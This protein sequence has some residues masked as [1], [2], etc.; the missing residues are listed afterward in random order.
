MDFGKNRIQYQNF[1][2]TY[3]DFERYRV[4]S[5]QGG[6]EISKYVSV[7]VAKQ[8]PLLEKR[9]DYQVDDKINI[10]V[11]NNQG[12]FKQS[13]LGLSSDDQNNIGGVTK[14]I[15][16]KISVFFNGSHA[17][18]DQQ[19]RAAL[20]ELLI[21][22]ILYGGNARD[23]LRNSTLLNLPPWYTQG[24]I[25]Y[26]SEGWTSYSDNLMYDDIKNDRFS[27]FNRLTG[28]EA[29]RAGHALWYDIVGTYGEALIP[30]LLYMTRVS[31]SPDNAFLFVLGV[32]L[33]N[34]IYDFTDAYNRRLFTFKDSLRKSPINN[35]SV[36]KKYK[37]IRH[38]S[39]LKLSPD[40][41]KVVYAR[42]ELNQIRVYLNEIG[43]NKH[44]RL[45]KYGPKIEQLDD[46]TYPILAWHPNG[47]IV[48]MI[49][50]R[51]DQ[52]VIYTV[53]L[54]SK[55]TFRRNLPGF[56]KINSASY[57]PDGKKLAL[58]AV[59][60]GKGQSDI[61]VYG[62]SSSAIEQITND[63]W[64]D[65]NAVFIKGSKQIVFESNRVN[66]TVKASDDASFFV[67]INRN[68]DLFMAPYPFRSKVLVRIT[69]TPDVNE[70]QAQPYTEQYVTYLSD[71]NGIYNRYIAEY[72]SSI[73]FVDTTE[74]YR[75]FFK[76]KVTSNFDRNLLE[77]NINLQ[78][79][80][81]ADVIFANGKNMLLV[82]PITTKLNEV[83]IPE[84]NNT[85]HK[86][87]TRPIVT[88]PS[89]YK[90]PAKPAE[91]ISPGRNGEP[92]ESGI[93]FDNYKFDGE[94][95]PPEKPADEAAK[96]VVRSDSAAKKPGASTAF[97]FPIQRNYYT[98]FYTDYVVT[99]F[100]NSFLA[101]NYQVFTGGGAP[102]YLNPGFNFLSK[103][104][105]SDLFEDQ[106]IVGG[107]RLNPSLDNEFMLSW[108]QRKKLFDHQVVLDRQTY[109]RAPITL[110][111]GVEFTGKVVTSTFK[112]S[113]KYPFNPVAAVRLSALLRNDKT[114][115]L[116]LGDFSLPRKPMFENLAGLRM[117]YIFDNTRKVMLNIMNGFRFKVWTEYWRFQD[118]ER[119]DLFTSGFDARHYLKI[120]RQITWCNRIAG[121]NSLGTDRLIFYLGGVDNWLNPTFNTNINIVNPSQYGFQTLATN[122]RGFNQNIRNGNNF[123][124]YNSELRI[125]VVRYLLNHPVRSDFLNNFQVIG[126]MDVG[127]AWNGLNPL[128][129]ENTENT[130]DYYYEG[131]SVIVTVVNQKNPLVAGTGFGLRS[132]L[133]GYF[134]RLD[135][136]WGIDNWVVQKRIIGLSL[137]T[138]F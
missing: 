127:M 51:K 134:V 119:R 98:S 3:F 24:L 49:Y 33:Q 53:D 77:Q 115:A 79:T 83:N 68:M 105:I 80:H 39:Q 123:L 57:S 61:F 32:S 116:S 8:L 25:K 136:G 71:K 31:R 124:V 130:Q 96:S 60:K 138:D 63:I 109:A 110:P 38:Y 76:S 137:T 92:T 82:T 5:Y 28:D 35:N 58:S 106:R 37:S 78:G 62:L 97:R 69:N 120:H 54:E 41:K 126:F 19:I 125:P 43:E 101:N 36:L 117:E 50:E 84:P 29:A 22:K 40:G 132:R 17:D 89:N 131:T 47:N 122:M 2:W 67:K 42:T 21:T 12:D 64:D 118:K 6:A 55:E 73:A 20:A 72:D 9:L 74:H 59:K 102:I 44:K 94:K 10:L 103:V 34:L 86:G 30:N 107:F 128:S 66:D 100:D 99:Q 112:Y 93:D 65:N 14:I 70:T 88:D 90:D 27:S 48:A 85:W 91:N 7:S 26:L 113:V 46:F 15:G 45:L 135:F 56:E 13:N 81:T 95:N 129:K 52:L 111:N 1:I 16:D 23:M 18:L 11:Y 121:G 104:A 133:L 4:Y 114:V 108:E 87:F 75:Y